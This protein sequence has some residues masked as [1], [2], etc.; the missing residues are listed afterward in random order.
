MIGM[1]LLCSDQ[2]DFSEII[3]IATLFFWEICLDH[4]CW[5]FNGLY[6][7]SMTTKFII[8]YEIKKRK[9]IMG[10]VLRLAER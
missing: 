8:R 7:Y 3:K 4:I 1:I 2:F 10:V 9:V 5:L 6:V